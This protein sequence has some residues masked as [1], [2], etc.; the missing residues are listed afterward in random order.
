MKCMRESDYEI[1]EGME[2]TVVL[3]RV[4]ERH[5]GRGKEKCVFLTLSKVWKGRY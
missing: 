3:C 2:G 4:D 1:W 5:E